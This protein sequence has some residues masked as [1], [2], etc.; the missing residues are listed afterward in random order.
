MDK[1]NPQCRV[2]QCFI[3]DNDTVF[4]CFTCKQDLC[5]SCRD[6]HLQDIST[7]YHDTVLYKLSK[8]RHENYFS[9]FSTLPSTLSSSSIK[10]RTIRRR[11]AIMLKLQ[12]DISMFSTQM[13]RYEIPLRFVT[14]AQHLTK[15]INMGCALP[16]YMFVEFTK[17]NTKNKKN[18]LLEYR[19]MNIE[20]KS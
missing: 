7:T 6:N 3:C 4:F 14:K 19:N 11:K 20:M 16:R 12:S 13:S 9:I 15:R 18:A 8:Q 2:R 10:I 1:S 17:Y 5:E